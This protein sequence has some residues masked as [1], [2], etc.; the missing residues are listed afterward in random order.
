MLP[1]PILK[2]AKLLGKMPHIGPKS[3][4]KLA[5]WFVTDGRG[6]A[7]ELG[8]ILTNLQNSIDI[9]DFC[10]YFIES[11]NTYCEF[12]SDPTRDALSI[13]IVEAQLDILDIEAS[14]AYKGKYFILGGVISPLEGKT[15]SDLPF[16]KLKNIVR[17]QEI[18]EIIIALGTTTEADVTAMYI[19][20]LLVDQNIKVT[21]LARGLSVGTS[22]RFAGKRSLAEAFKGRENF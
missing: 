18:K 20:E 9:C 14:G 1:L 6:L 15:I 2:L 21:S 5:V 4:E 16:D 7:P 22:I 13:C 11:G 12:C 8:S 3:A 17:E 19:K 10:G